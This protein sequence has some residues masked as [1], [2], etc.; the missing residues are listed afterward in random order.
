MAAIVFTP[1]L[2]GA[3]ATA[4]RIGAETSMVAGDMRPSNDRTRPA[5]V[6]FSIQEIF[7]MEV[8]HRILFAAHQSEITA[9]LAIVLD[10]L[11]S[12]M[13]K[14]PDQSITIVGHADDPGTEAYNQALSEERAEAVLDYLIAK[15]IL[16]DRLRTVGY[17]RERPA[18]LGTDEDAQAQNRRVIFVIKGPDLE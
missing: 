3:Q 17:S 15:G 10:R 11:V 8:G 4:I 7:L 1:G 5:D 2:P 14:Y 6:P 12:W 13:N 9:E 16:P 18:F